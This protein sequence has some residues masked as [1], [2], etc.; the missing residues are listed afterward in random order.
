MNA[1]EVLGVSENASLDEIRKAYKDLVKK[2]H[3]DK[4]KDNPLS[5]LAQDKLKQINEAYDELCKLHGANGSSYDSHSSS[6]YGY[7]SSSEAFSRVRMY[8]QQNNLSAAQQA[9]NASSDRGAE[10][11]YLQGVIYLRQGQYDRAREHMARAAQAEPSNSEYVN[12]YNSLN[13]MNYSYRGGYRQSGMGGNDA[14]KIC[15]GLYCA[16]CCCECCG[17]DLI[18]CC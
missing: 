10:W 8:L 9:L 7:S 14:C 2:Y 3:P 11:N 6:K 1:Y 12:A 13:N 4:Y 17:G 15:G 18:P 5:D 16:D